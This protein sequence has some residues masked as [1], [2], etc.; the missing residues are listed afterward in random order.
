MRFSR[1]CSGL[2]CCCSGTSTS[3]I[4]CSQAFARGYPP[5]RLDVV[6]ASDGSTDGTAAR[7]GAYAGARLSVEE[8]RLRRGKA[9]VL[10]D[11]VP[12]T[13]GEIVILADARQLF[14]AGSVKALVSNFADPTVGAVSGELMLE[15]AASTTG[16]G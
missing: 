15:A 11:V 10:N 9:A 2:G 7:A 8:F 5:D 16:A 1:L 13:R 12:S 6:I 14:E 3:A 4:H